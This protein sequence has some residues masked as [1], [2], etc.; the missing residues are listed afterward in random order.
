MQITTADGDFVKNK[1]IDIKFK[2]LKDLK[3]NYYYFFGIWVIY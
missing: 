3:P 2:F 1:K